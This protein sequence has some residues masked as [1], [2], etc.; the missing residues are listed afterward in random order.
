[1][2]RVVKGERQ[3]QHALEVLRHRAQPAAMSHTI[4]LQGDHDVRDDAAQSDD[5][6]YDEQLRAWAQSSAVDSLLAFDNRSTTL[7]NST[8]S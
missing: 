3:D 4:G 5:G 7:P 8:G 1:M 6:P 2:L